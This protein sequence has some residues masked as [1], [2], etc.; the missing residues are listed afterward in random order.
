MFI[1]DE[2][3]KRVC[4]RPQRGHVRELHSESAIYSRV[5]SRDVTRLGQDRFLEVA[6]QKNILN[7]KPRT[8]RTV[9]W[10]GNEQS[11]A[12]VY[13]DRLLHRSLLIQGVIGNL[14]H[15]QIREGEV[16]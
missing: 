2:R 12:S 9:Y 14:P 7:P 5:W 3:Y 8:N 15:V 11:I 4:T 16:I 1:C 6:K 10:L 13:K